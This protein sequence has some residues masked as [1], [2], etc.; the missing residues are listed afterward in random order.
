[1][2]RVLLVDG[3]AKVRWGLRM[4]LTIEPD[5]TVV[6]ETGNFEEALALAQALAPDV[7]VVDT[8][9][10]AGEGVNSVKRL[11]AAAPAALVIVLTLQG[12]EG[13]RARAQEAGA[14]AF[15]EKQGGAADLLQA[16]RLLA[17]RR[18]PEATRPA[19]GALAARQLGAG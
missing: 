5:V 14:Q 15:L 3:Q 16:I 19:T 4:R 1:M 12:D 6:G 18:L 9:M 11:R 13:T 2:N 7:I 17:S 10:H 8:C